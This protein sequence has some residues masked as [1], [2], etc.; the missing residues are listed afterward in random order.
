MN[1]YLSP[2]IRVGPDIRLSGNKSRISGNIRQDM[3]DIRPDIRHPAKK[4]HIRPKS[5][6]FQFLNFSVKSKVLNLEFLKLSSSILEFS[7]PSQI[8]DSGHV[9]KAYGMKNPCAAEKNDYLP[10]FD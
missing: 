9:Y 4:N 5:Q 7:V 2:N 8:S 10:F 6:I 1:S 3:P